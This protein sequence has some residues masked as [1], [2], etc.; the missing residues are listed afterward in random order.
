MR[1]SSC[2]LRL[3]LA[4]ALTAF[5]C[6]SARAADEA[7]TRVRV[8]KVVTAP[9]VDILHA[10]GRVFSS[11]AATLSFGAAGTVAKINVKDGDVV[12]KGDVLA[13]LD[14]SYQNLQVQYRETRLKI[15]QAELDRARKNK[16]ADPDETVAAL[17]CQAAENELAADRV[18]LEM[19]KLTAPIDGV[20]IGL[21]LVPGERVGALVPVARILNP[22]ADS[23]DFDV[24][25]KSLPVVAPKQALIIQA[26]NYPDRNF[27]GLVD[28]VFPVIDP[29]TG[30]FLVR[31]RVENP[32]ALLLPGMAAGVGVVLY[33]KPD[34]LLLPKEA[35]FIGDDGAYTAF[36]V[37][38]NS[39]VTLVKLQVE[40]LGNPDV[41]VISSG[42]AQGDRVVLTQS[43][44]GLKNGA[45]VQV[46]E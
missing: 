35:L 22:A 14:S 34:A 46:L 39:V 26:G 10:T 8:G 16:N 7:V 44:P 30:S 43:R 4:T 20:I 29:K 45:K 2:V 28:R 9:L 3:M 15:A 12:K 6:L 38:A 24:P 19:N 32:D 27:K 11:S 33:S 25:E 31:G 36:K 41:A 1:N 23:V 37:D 18:E 42:L 13:E 17:K 21:S 5:G 40:Y